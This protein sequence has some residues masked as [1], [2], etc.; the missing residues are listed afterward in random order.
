MS[1]S[2][3]DGVIHFLNVS[4]DELPTRHWAARMSLGHT[5]TTGAGGAPSHQQCQM[6]FH[7]HGSVHNTARGGN[8]NAA[9]SWADFPAAR[10]QQHAMEYSYYVY[11]DIDSPSSTE[12]RSGPWPSESYL[13]EP[14]SAETAY[15][16][17]HI[18][19]HSDSQ[20]SEYSSAAVT[21]TNFWASVSETEPM[22]S[23]TLDDTNENSG[24]FSVPPNYFEPPM[25]LWCESHPPVYSGAESMHHLAPHSQQ[26]VDT[27]A[28]LSASFER[29]QSRYNRSG[30][31]LLVAAEN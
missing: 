23:E 30:E 4:L 27:P 21:P 3:I 22:S 2:Y 20:F 12:H 9:T 14:Y 5:A 26:A 31:Q 13:S 19:G 11:R 18:Y 15:S 17:F 8:A 28:W 10:M 16:N 25:P 6:S 1:V 24:D 29:S 7:T